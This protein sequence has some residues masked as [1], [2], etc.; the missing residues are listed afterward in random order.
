MKLDWKIVSIVIVALL[1]VI[2]VVCVAITHGHDGVMA[3]TAIS[4]FFGLAMWLCGDKTGRQRLV[5]ALKALQDKE[6]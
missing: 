6:E 1:G 3:L 4:G 5:K 2:A